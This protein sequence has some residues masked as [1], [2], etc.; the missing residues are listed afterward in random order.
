MKGNSKFEFTLIIMLLK[1]TFG[2]W[3][4]RQRGC[5]VN[6]FTCRMTNVPLSPYGIKLKIVEQIVNMYTLLIVRP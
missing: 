1:L 2:F 3:A 4:F 6:V 5:N